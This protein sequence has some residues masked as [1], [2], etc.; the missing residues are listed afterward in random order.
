MSVLQW[1]YLGNT[2]GAWLM[3]VLV[4]VIV[5]VGLRTVRGLVIR[6]LTSLSARTETEVDDIVAVALRR[7]KLFFLAFLSFYSA[8][9]VLLLPAQADVMLRYVGVVVIIVQAALWGNVIINS[10]IRRQMAQRMEEDAATA[11]TV[12]AI[13]FISRLAFYTILILLGLSNLGID[14]TALVAGLG[15]G[16]IAVALA[17]Q[18]VLGDL[19]ASLSI[20][21]DRPFVIGDF[22]IVGDM[23]GTVE[24]I[25]LKT[26]RV[27]SLSGEQLIISNG[28]LLTA[29]IRNYQK[30]SERRIAFTI[31]VTYQTPR[32]LI[33]R[34]PTMIREAVE[35]QEDAR[36]DRSHFATY[37]DFSLAFE[38][39]YYVLKPDYAVYMDVQQAINLE[40]LAR[41]EAAGIEFA[42]PTQTLIMQHG[43][44]S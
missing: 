3:A 10:A 11:T 43:G 15:I 33:Q 35:L 22:V 16:G 5:Y 13:G 2:A 32:S 31:G 23:S 37:G 18:N 25:G 44:A 36:F 41:F 20:V 8:T 1:E 40:I 27:R 39:V 24:Y 21:L 29:R 17:L 6:Q 9:R 30:M 12:N 19:F 26:T 4:G 42:Y 14:I 34:I 7:T 28:D 38:T